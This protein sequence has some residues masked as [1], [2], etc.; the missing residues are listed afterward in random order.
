MKERKFLL[1]TFLFVFSLSSILIAW[2]PGTHAHFAHKLGAK[3]GILN[4]Q[5]IYGSTLPD[6]FNLA[7]GLPGQDSLA[8]WAHYNYMPVADKAW[9]CYLKSI[10]Y[11]FVSH[12]DEW[13]ADFKAHGYNTEPSSGWVEQK[14]PGLAVEIYEPIFDVVGE[15]L[16]L[17]LPPEE[18]EEIVWGLAYSLSHDF[19]E[20]GV[21][22]LL[23]MNVDPDIGYRLLLAAQLRAPGTPYLLASAYAKDLK[24]VSQ[25]NIIQASAIIIQAEK[26]YRDLMISYGMI[27]TKEDDEMMQM[28]C[29]LAADLITVQLEPLLGFELPVD[30]ETIGDLLQ[31]TLDYLVV[32]NQ[33]DYL[34]EL[35]ATLIYLED[36]MA[37]EGFYSGFSLFSKT[38]QV[39][40]NINSID[41]ETP[42]NYSLEQN[43]PNPFNPVTT[44]QYSLVETEHVKLDVF[45]YL[46]QQVA[47]LVDQVCSEGVHRVEWDASHL[48]SGI[49]FYRIQTKN[50]TATKKMYLVK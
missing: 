1:L 24:E 50:F 19:I 28:L 18:V 42:L 14:V 26:A 32:V 38:D 8:K 6:V 34:D 33:S 40:E 3:R 15:Y 11:G 37:E 30:P 47:T 21:D 39:D 43:Y 31:A 35:D 10:A 25:L 48:S 23:K 49:Y 5:E 2:N 45:N 36:K 46:G 27:F 16:L 4:L 12:N 17:Q 41:T 9:S 7:Y 29:E 22:I 44:V 13:G 20:T